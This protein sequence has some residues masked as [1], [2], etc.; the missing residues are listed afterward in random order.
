M[1]LLLSLTITNMVKVA[2]HFSLLFMPP[3]TASEGR[4]F[5]FKKLIRCV[6]AVLLTVAM[7]GGF[8]PVSSVHAASTYYVA[9]NGSNSNPGTESEPFLTIQYGISQMQS[10]DSLLIKAGTYNEAVTVS[11]KSGILIRNYRYD[12]VIV[13]NTGA[14]TF[15]N[16][17]D[18]TLQGISLKTSIVMSGCTSLKAT[19][20]D[21]EGMVFVSGNSSGCELSASAI[22]NCTDEAAI[23]L[24]GAAS[25][26]IINNVIRNNPDKG[27]ELE[28]SGTTNNIVY[29]NTFYGNNVDILLVYSTSIGSPSGTNIKNNIISNEIQIG[30]SSLLTNNVFDYNC[31]N[32]VNLSNRIGYISNTYPSGLSLL[33]FQE[34]GYE[35]HGFLGD[36]V[37]KNAAN[38]D[39]RLEKYSRCIGVGCTGTNVPA[40]DIQGLT[41]TQPYDVGAYMYRDVLRSLYVSTGGSN[42]N[43]GTEADPF[44][45]I[46]YAISQLQPGDEL[47]IRG[48]TYNEIL[49][50][51]SMNN[52]TIRNFKGENVT[53]QSTSAFNFLSCSNVILNGIMLNTSLN[54][55]GCSGLKATKLDVQG[56]ISI[57][58]NSDGCELSASVIHDYTGNAAVL[59]DNAR[60][61]QIINNVI[62]NNT[63]IGLE[64][65]GGGTGNDN[66][67][68][69]T[70]YGN[71]AD[72]SLYYGAGTGNPSNNRIKN[73][74][75]SNEIQIGN[76]SLLSVNTFNYNCYNSANLSQRIGYIVDTYP[77]GLSLTQFQQLGYEVGGFVGAPAFKDIVNKDFRLSE[78]S[79][80][81][82]VG[83]SEEGL[84]LRDFS[85][86]PRTSPYDIGAYKFIK[87]IYYISPS[88]NNNNN[89][90]ITSPWRTILYGM[91]SL[92]SGDV[93][94]IRDGVYNERVDISQKTGSSTAWYTVT[95]YPDESPVMNSADSQNVAIKLSAS[96][97]WVIDG[98]KMTSYLG[99]GVWIATSGTGTRCDSIL[100]QNLTIWD[101]ADPTYVTSG[102]EGILGDGG[103]HVTA[104]NCHIYDIGLD[105]RSQ[106]DH[107]IY[108]GYGAEGWIFDSNRIHNST[109]SGIQ[110]YGHP[111]GGDY[112]IVKNNIIYNN[113]Y[114]LILT[115]GYGNVIT[116]N[117]LYDN[118]D[119]DLYFD[120]SYS[121][122]TVQNNILY[123]TTYPNG[124]KVLIEDRINQT[125]MEYTVHNTTMRF[126]DGTSSMSNTFRNNVM[127]KS[128]GVQILVN[129]TYM[130]L[131]S[132]YSTYS[133]PS[134]GIETDP[135]FNYRDIGDFRLT[136]TSP[137]I[138]YGTPVSS[139]AV[140]YT[141]KTRISNP[142]AGAYEYMTYAVNPSADAH[143]R[144]GSYANTNFGLA[145]SLVVK[146]EP[147]TGYSRESYLKFDLS[148]LG[149]N[150]C[151][152][153]KLKIYCTYADANTPVQV[154]TVSDDSWSETGITWNNRPSTDTS[155]SASQTISNTYTWYT[156][157]IT[158][159]VN[160]ELSGDKT[161]G[162]CL[163]DMTAAGKGIDFNSKEALSN[164]VVLEVVPCPTN[165][166]TVNPSI[167]A[168]VRDGSYSDTNFGSATSLVVKNEPVAGYRR[169]AYLKF[170][171]S[172]LGMVRCSSAK[173]KIYC[174]YADTSTPV[175]AYT[176]SDDSWS[177][178]GI[179]WN[180]RPAT[181]TIALSTQS[182]SNTGTWYTFDITS[183]VSAELEGDKT[184]AICLKDVTTA[185]KGMN[186]N[187]REA[188][189]YKAKL[190]ILPFN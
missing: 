74:I 163:K 25:T 108:I 140:D 67:Y 90:S 86:L 46:Q 14:F 122:N 148:S 51:S 37:F 81:R 110:M 10:G 15:T 60:N 189:S 119:C 175:Q 153:A 54:I 141:Y 97:Y 66:I 112:C 63:A 101:I 65:K 48:G 22:H 89:G 98:L 30:N 64:L 24:Y 72:I 156:F 38:Y 20:L 111:S 116:N 137:C 76:S 49:T 143:V 27:I 158:A 93:L 42:S 128:T 134:M 114:G 106:A 139:P 124:Y 177:E 17:Q 40:T 120:W 35:R 157:D 188:S 155:S 138:N 52:L 57:N 182:V 173:L 104:R 172:S 19:G 70:F 53:L 85:G 190:E 95:N 129:S 150:G 13:Q 113:K 121:S 159:C 2:H 18:S 117:T 9:A 50:V 183:F 61:S 92:Q 180:N 107:G 170:D 165:A 100:V 136:A 26:R 178:T 28:G 32:N 68:C 75:I 87:N 149:I 69:N 21:V 167:D 105:R 88:G 91:Q 55:N 162:I 94:Y 1:Y 80:C 45:T 82:G 31:Y 16:C 169:E 23:L 151:S 187:S 12:A 96:T 161:V 166:T 109:G 126:C 62:R 41:R 130:S 132:F 123:N 146:N 176:V 6:I 154:Y 125:L 186:F 7:I 83:T 43:P 115:E 47:V 174:T 29:N 171:L 179:T 102:T 184:V 135:L 11:G 4:I 59:I 73:N 58:N 103:D 36:P 84:P 127:Y 99:A 144:D 39:F 181:G 145:T 33:Q 3:A 8:V 56:S 78:T 168:Y 34:I 152:S 131:A 5:R 160:S 164:K 77:N 147:V 185:S 133:I 118:W 142:D 71:S 44:L 79:A